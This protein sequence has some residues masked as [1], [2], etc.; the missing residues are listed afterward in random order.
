M[1]TPPLAFLLQSLQVLNFRVY[2]VPW[3]DTGNKYKL[4]GYIINNQNKIMSEQET[5]GIEAEEITT[6]ETTS[7]EPTQEVA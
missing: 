4:K 7:S 2:F 1:E 6:S 3:F 5:T